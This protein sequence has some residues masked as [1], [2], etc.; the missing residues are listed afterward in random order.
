MDMKS[1]VFALF[2]VIYLLQD[3]NMICAR[4]ELGEYWKNM[5]MEQPMPE[6]IKELIEDRG[7]L[8]LSE[9][10]GGKNRFTRDFDIKPNVILYHTATHHNHEPQFM[11][12]QDQMVEQIKS[13]N[14]EKG[15]N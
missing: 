5:M 12:I 11:M 15:L 9:S 4:K 10:D 6:S 8:V 13:T 2:L 14:D 7:G 3:A 1:V